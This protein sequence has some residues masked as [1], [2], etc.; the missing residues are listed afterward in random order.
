MLPMVA[1]IVGSHFV[2]G[3]TV[4]IP[5]PIDSKIGPDPG[6][7]RQYLGSEGRSDQLPDDQS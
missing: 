6:E 2:D 7:P 5:P 1:D 3:L 4:G